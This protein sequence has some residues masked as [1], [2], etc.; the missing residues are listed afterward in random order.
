MS[1]IVIK[2]NEVLKY[3]EVAEEKLALLKNEIEEIVNTHKLSKSNT[4]KIIVSVTSNNGGR[5]I[6]NVKTH[7][8]EYTTTE[9][10]CNICSANF[11]EEELSI[12]EAIALNITLILDNLDEII[13]RDNKHTN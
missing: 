2:E 13:E 4:Y 12:K 1:K 9:S 3:E 10:I 6:I 5:V 11:G 8:E 7:I